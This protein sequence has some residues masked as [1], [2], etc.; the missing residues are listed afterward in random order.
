VADH[1]SL[2]WLIVGL[3]LATA[4]LFGFRDLVFKPRS[5]GI[6]DK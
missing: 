4:Y 2:S 6:A 5:Q 3:G 1:R